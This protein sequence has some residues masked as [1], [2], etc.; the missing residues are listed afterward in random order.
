MRRWLGLLLG[1]G[2]GSLVTGVCLLG[3]AALWSAWAGR[4]SAPTPSL[5]MTTPAAALPPATPVPAAGSPDPYLRELAP[6]TPSLGA[7]DPLSGGAL[8]VSRPALQRPFEAQGFDFQPVE[9]GDGRARWVAAAPDGLALVEIVGAEQVEF[10]SVTAFGSSSQAAEQAAQQVVYLLTMLNAILPGWPEGAE[11]LSREVVK[12]TR[13]TGDYRSEIVSA[14]VRVGFTV[15]SQL[16]A[17]T[18]SFRAE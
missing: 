6:P 4:A 16:H 9:L 10:A 13:Q 11:W 18:L 8:P 3:A 12:S 17:V 15:E 14:G 2:A 1:A 7:P 5:S